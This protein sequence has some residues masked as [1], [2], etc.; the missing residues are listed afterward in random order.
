MNYHHE[1]RAGDATGGFEIQQAERLADVDVI[2]WRKTE[3]ARL[4]MARHFDVG[5]L[6]GPVRHRL[7]QQVRHLELPAVQVRL[8]GTQLLLGVRQAGGQRLTLLQQRR[9]IL[10]ASARLT[11]RLGLAV[12][13]RAQAIGLD[14]PVAALLLQ[15]LPG[16]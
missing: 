9:D 3:L 5:A 16:N 8:H 1:A 11:D 10:T 15:L 13:R 6:V 12:A 14:L 2:A 7:V 4:P